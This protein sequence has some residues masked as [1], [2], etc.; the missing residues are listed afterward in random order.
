MKNLKLISAL[1]IVF[2]AI[3]FTPAKAQRVMQNFESG[4]MAIDVSNY[5]GFYNILYDKSTNYHINEEWA[6]KNTRISASR[7][8]TWVKSPWVLMASGSIT[9][10]MKMDETRNDPRGYV[11]YAIPYDASKADGEGTPVKLDS[12]SVTADANNTILEL[13]VAVPA[14]MVG[15]LYKIQLSFVGMGSGSKTSV[16]DFSIPGTYYSNPANHGLPFGP[17]VDT[18]GDGVPDAEDQYPNDEYRAYNN[19][20]PTVGTQG[21]LAF[22]D[23]WP[24]IGDYDFNDVVVDYNINTVTNASNQ[25]VEVISQFKLKA[26]G[27]SYNDGFG[28]Q[29]DNIAPNKIT[30]VTGTNYGAGTYISTG[31]NGLES[32]QTYANCIVFD[33][34]FRLMPRVGNWVG[35]NTETAA[36]FV[37]YQNMTVT[38]TFMNN[39]VAPAGGATLL[40]ALPSSAFNFY[41]ISDK[42]RGYEIHLANRVPS[43]LANHALLGTMQDTSAGARTYVTAHNLP[44][45]INIV[46]GFSYPIEGAPLNDAYLKLIPWAESGG[47]SYSDWYSNQ[48]GYRAAELIY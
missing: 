3:T 31:N 7:L 44:W 45:G 19:Y 46:Q 10:F 41:I 34:F 9:F 35:V 38:L 20:Y 29:L 11:A 22:E 25:V 26:S 13:S 1:V 36:P 21:T 17:V 18:D 14:G 5:W 32:G 2:L 12:A 47:S 6:G 24:E 37:P 4:D 42:R 28:F 15:S 39:G 16:D 48:S 40:T 33:E 23:K 8:D 27:A 30:S 43:T